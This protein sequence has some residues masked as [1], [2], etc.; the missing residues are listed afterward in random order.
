MPPLLYQ[1][2]RGMPKRVPAESPPPRAAPAAIPAPVFAKPR[3][4]A[5]AAPAE[6]KA[7]IVPTKKAA[8]AAAKPVALSPPR[9]VVTAAST[10]TVLADLTPSCIAD[11]QPSCSRCP[12][13]EVHRHVVAG[14]VATR[15]EAFAAL[16]AAVGSQRKH[17]ADVATWQQ[18]LKAMREQLADAQAQVQQQRSIKPAVSTAEAELALARSKA[19]EQERAYR[20]LQ[21]HYQDAMQQITAPQ[22]EVQRLQSSSS[23]ASSSASSSPPNAL[24]GLTEL[25]RQQLALRTGTQ[26]TLERLQQLFPDQKIG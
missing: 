1:L 13:C 20:A 23:S 7:A 24:A 9:A 16:E 15:N 18:K 14:I 26:Q 6:K 10:Q 8:A 21:Q 12:C 5:V 2:Q 25:Q 17:D 3:K 19:D 4:V 11:G 22:L